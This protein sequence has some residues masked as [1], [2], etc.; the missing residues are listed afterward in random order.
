MGVDL[1]RLTPLPTNEKKTKPDSLH[2]VP[3]IK[4]IRMKAPE[5]L[6]KVK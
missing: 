5:K 6:G 1:S 2:Y 4:E 3:E